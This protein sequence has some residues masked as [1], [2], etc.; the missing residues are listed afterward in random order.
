M[1]KPLVAGIA[2]ALCLVAV[3]Q[4]QTCKLPD[5]AGVVPMQPVPASDLMTVPVGINGA[6]RKFLLDVSM[7]PTQISQATVTELHI[8]EAAK[9]TEALSLTLAAGGNADAYDQTLV[10]MFD[11]E[12]HVPVYDARSGFGGGAK[13][14]AVNIA[15]F[16][17]GD[18]ELKNRQ[19][20]I[21]LDPD[22]GRVEPWDGLMTGDFL[23]NYDVELDFK[24]KHI[25]YLTPNTCTDPNQVVFW[26][27]TIVGIVPMAIA[28]DGHIQVQVNAMGHVIDAEIDTSSA[29]SVMRRGVAEQTLGLQPGTPQMVLIDGVKDGEGEPVYQALFTRIS[30]AQGIEVVNFPVQVQTNSMIRNPERRAL[31]GSRAQFNDVKIPALTIGMDV[32]RQLHIYA[33]YKQNRLYVTPADKPKP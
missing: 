18:S 4:A 23:R 14:S 9:L 30:F 5:I 10:H 22:M 2:A 19:F 25:T 11:S 13:R 15:S 16:T 3:A 31:T 33:V 7:E 28:P 24:D 32:L 26:S 21:A 20:L 6:P 17:I 8:P 27:H 12:M 29:H 1:L